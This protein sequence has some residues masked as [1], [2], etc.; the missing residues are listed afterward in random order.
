MNLYI[1]LIKKF[2]F[3]SKAGPHAAFCGFSS[4]GCE[5]GSNTTYRLLTDDGVR[6]TH[7]LKIIGAKD[8]YYANLYKK[9]P[10]KPS[11]RATLVAWDP[12]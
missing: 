4:D 8:N 10:P 12:V 7:G 5:V 11:S 2:I 1:I 3:L 6:G 9:N